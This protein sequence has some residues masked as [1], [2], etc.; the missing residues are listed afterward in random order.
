MAG[1]WHKHVHYDTYLQ[2]SGAYFYFSSD[3]KFIIKQIPTIEAQAF[4]RTLPDYY[5]FITQHPNSFL[6]RYF[7]FFMLDHAYYI[8][9]KNVFTTQHVIHETY[10]LKG[11]KIARSNPQGPIYKD[12]D[13]LQEVDVGAAK[14]KQLIGIINEGI[15][16]NTCVYNKV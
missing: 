8:V 15:Y 12:N 1:M 4:R 13:L 9:M 11:S 5:N 6:C 16:C 2:R 14:R 7:G 10:D 3:G